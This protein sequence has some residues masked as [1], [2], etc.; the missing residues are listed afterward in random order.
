MY[1]TIDVQPVVLARK[2]NTSIVHKGHVKALSMLNLKIKKYNFP[3]IFS[4]TFSITSHIFTPPN[5]N[6]I[7]CKYLYKKFISGR[8]AGMID[9]QGSKFNYM[10]R[11]CG[12]IIFQKLYL[13]LQSRD[14]LPVLRKDGEVEVIVVVCD[15]YLP[16]SIYAN[17]NWIV[18]DT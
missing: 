11:K 3:F 16:C 15:G 4:L 10:V 5:R 1:V 6:P 2:Y 13:A 17:T 18:G 12:G 9:H 7:K 8:L 14:K